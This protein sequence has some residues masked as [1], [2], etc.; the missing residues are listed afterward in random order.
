MC[1]DRYAMCSVRVMLMTGVV[2]LLL[3]PTLSS[4]VAVIS[5]QCHAQSNRSLF[6]H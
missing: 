1:V 4:F 2:L 6:T 3:L 5:A